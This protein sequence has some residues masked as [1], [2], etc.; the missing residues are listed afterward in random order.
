M[1]SK[2]VTVDDQEI[3]HL[4]NVSFNLLTNI[5][6]QTNLSEHIDPIYKIYFRVKPIFN[7]LNIDQKHH[8]NRNFILQSNRSSVIVLVRSNQCYFN[9]FG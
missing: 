5:D 1:G 9:L 2:T 7:R 8:V 3:I 4:R 6:L